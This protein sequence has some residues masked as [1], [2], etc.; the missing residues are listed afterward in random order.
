MPYTKSN[1]KATTT[2]LSYGL[3]VSTVSTLVTYWTATKLF[4]TKGDKQTLLILNSADTFKLLIRTRYHI[5]GNTTM[6]EDIYGTQ[7]ARDV[8]NDVMQELL[9]GLPVHTVEV[10]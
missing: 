10:A 9:T 5:A 1:T 6:L 7:F 3:L 8:V 2:P 4:S